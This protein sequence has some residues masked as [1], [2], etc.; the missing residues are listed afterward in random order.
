MISNRKIIVIGL[1]IIAGCLDVSCRLGKS[2]MGGSFAVSS[3]DGNL[4]ITISLAAKPQPYLPG[5]RAYYRVVYKGAAILNDSSLGLDF[6]GA[7]PLDQDF[8]VV[9]TDRKSGNLTWENPF[10]A[11][12]TVP[13]HYNEMTVSLQEK[14]APGR[15]VDL[16]FRA[17]D[18]GVAFRYVLPK[19][20][21]LGDFTLAA[22]NTGFYFANGTASSPAGHASETERGAGSGVVS[23]SAG[24]SAFALNMGQFNTQNE[25]EYLRTALR[26][27]KP[28]SIVNLPLLVEM[29]GGGPW[30]ALL[31][32]DLTDYAGMYVGGVPGIPN[33]LTAKLST[34]PDRKAEQ[35]VVGT[36]PKVTPWRIVM[37]A[38]T[39]GRLIE[40][41]YLVLNL[42]A[43]CALTDT[44]WIKPGKAA[45]D[46]WSGSYATGVKFKPGMNTATTKHYIDFAAAHRL[47]YMLVD[48]GWAPAPPGER[49]EDILHFIPEANVPDIIAYGRAKGVRVLL[50][51]EW[52]A[53]DAHMD[54]AM[55]LFEK[56]GAAG[57]KV[58]YMNR[59]D[60]EMVN[61]YEKVVRKAAE[62]RLTV[63]FHGAY[64]GTGLRRTYPNLLTRE[65]VMGMEYNKWTER[66]TPE[67]DVTIPFTRM[68]AGPM[69]FTPGA[70][71]NAARGKFKAL[72]IA[73]MSQ[74]TRAHQLAMYVVYESPLVMVSDYPE[75]Y[76]GQP[77]LEFIEKVPTVWDETKVIGGEPAKFV[78]VARR[79]GDSWYIGAM[80]NWDARDLEVPLGFLGAGEYE[81]KIFADGPAAETDGTSLSASAIR[82][83][84]DKKITLHLAS[85]GGAAVILTPAK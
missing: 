33:A 18:E 4:T 32:A 21:A 37:V 55:A 73:P 56:W 31:E 9:A 62:H 53:L 39:P 36:T 70:M 10:G 69:D 65:G 76:A 28:A 63:D 66:V 2:S 8:E 45:W 11:R 7:S 35:A 48:A 52:R 14:K 15:R 50:W 23:P 42:S 6:L 29:P 60:Q 54:E 38:P 25:G 26:D 85:G 64:K 71:R 24:P 12:R 5:E 68:L 43:P 19:Q 44:S 41:N 58:D 79:S 49:L 72:D 83:S 84:A 82:I 80:T 27:I 13:D 20:E 22:E 78:A 3:P 51:V 46:W 40:T 1:I 74:G 75:A 30:V 57:I 67:H 16:V 34:P 17:Y 77:G 61:Y 81:A 47:Q 59:D